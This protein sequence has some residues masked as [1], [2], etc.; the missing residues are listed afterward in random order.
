MTV[1]PRAGWV[2]FREHIWLC[3]PDPWQYWQ[4]SYHGVMAVSLW[5]LAGSLLS[6]HGAYWWCAEGKDGCSR[7]ITIYP[8]FITATNKKVAN[9]R[10]Q[11]G[12]LKRCIPSRFASTALLPCSSFASESGPFN[13]RI[14]GWWR[15]TIST[16]LR[17]QPY[18]LRVKGAS[19]MER[20]R[21][22][23]GSRYF[24]DNLGQLVS[25]NNPFVLNIGEEFSCF[26]GAIN[27]HYD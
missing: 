4:Y 12:T 6:I 9:C 2:P 14:T 1:Q 5:P 19:L 22:F 16:F 20:H 8:S 27:N 24:L 3:D 11:L 18:Q 25:W 7:P 10:Q 13:D 21:L 15:L 26:F 23:F 17:F